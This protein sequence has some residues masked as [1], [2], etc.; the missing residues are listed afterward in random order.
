MSAES[1]QILGSI[2]RLRSEN[3]SGMTR[4]DS[5]IETLRAE[6]NE[7]MQRLDSKIEN[8][9]AKIDHVA[10]AL[11]SEIAGVRTTATRAS[12]DV[13]TL[14]GVQRGREQAAQE[15]SGNTGKFAIPPARPPS[16]SSHDFTAGAGPTP[17]A[18][19]IVMPTPPAGVDVELRI[20]KGKKHDSLPPVIGWI[21]RM[22]SRVFRSTAGKIG[23]FFGAALI[24]FLGR[25]VADPVFARTAA[26]SESGT[27]ASV[28]TAAPPASTSTLMLDAG[29]PELG[30]HP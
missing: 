7:G 4:L 25:H 3:N 13:A 11:R 19:T 12:N 28:A 16:P 29:R 20:G 5:K 15:F 8:T 1:E 17:P 21:A 10:T 27:A 23:G 22:V 30:R 26:A 9:N 6:N 14:K 2:E 24:G 18:G